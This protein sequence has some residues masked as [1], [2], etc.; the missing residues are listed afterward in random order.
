MGATTVM[1]EVFNERDAHLLLPP[2]AIEL[3]WQKPMGC[4][5]DPYVPLAE[6]KLIAKLFTPDSSWTW[7]VLEGEPM[8][9]QPTPEN[10]VVDWMLYGL[11]SGMEVEIGSFLLSELQAARG[12]LGLPVERDLWYGQDDWKREVEKLQE[13][14]VLA[15]TI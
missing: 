9:V 4:Y 1:T 6:R 14:G 2:S 5:E 3:L 8:G 13:R 7:W 10:G 12:K 11:V 15:S